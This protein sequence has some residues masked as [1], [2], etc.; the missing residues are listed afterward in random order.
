[1]TTFIVKLSVNKLV[2]TVVPD[3]YK[4]Y[5]LAHFAAL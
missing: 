4:A 2:C 5:I 1:M 3:G